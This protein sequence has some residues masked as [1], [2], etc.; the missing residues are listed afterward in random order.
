M[1]TSNKYT[2]FTYVYPFS[3]SLSWISP[4]HLCHSQLKV[5]T[6]TC[7]LLYDSVL[8]FCLPYCRMTN[9]DR[10][11]QKC[12]QKFVSCFVLSC[13]ISP[14]FRW[15][16]RQTIAT[17]TPILILLPMSVYKLLYTNLA[18]AFRNTNEGR[19]CFNLD[20]SARYS[21]C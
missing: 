16:L 15:L 8:W 14:G 5:N 3:L 4:S 20:Y 7:F 17:E 13:I 11:G 1:I 9:Q 10:R 21:M 12:D 18:P 2:H 6:S 19:K